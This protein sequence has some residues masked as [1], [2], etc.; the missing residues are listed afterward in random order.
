MTQP[1]LSVWSYP[2]QL[3]RAPTSRTCV[4]DWQL[5]SY[6]RYEVGAQR[7][8]SCGRRSM[9][10]PLLQCP[11][12]SFLL[13]GTHGCTCTH[14]MGNTKEEAGLVSSPS[15]LCYLTGN[16]EEGPHGG[17]D[18]F[19]GPSGRCWCELLLKTLDREHSSKV[20]DGPAP[21]LPRLSLLWLLP[22]SRDSAWNSPNSLTKHSA[23][24]CSLRL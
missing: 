13:F 15:L 1:L 24:L 18:T 19:C 2:S 16:Q 17:G 9:V 3:L 21:L 23:S 4:W 11:Q 7:T 5:N 10:C 6:G 8:C 20:S 12:P 14:N 22:R